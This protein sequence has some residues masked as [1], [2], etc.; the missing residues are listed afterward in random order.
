MQQQSSPSFPRHA[1][2]AALVTAG[3]ALVPAGA[4][5]LD[6][7]SIKEY[8]SPSGFRVIVKEAHGV[9]LAAIQVWI[10][11]GGY[12]ETEQTNGFAHAIEHMVFKGGQGRGPGD[13]DFKIESLGGLL[14]AATNKDWTQFA[15][16]VASQHAGQALNLMGEA[17]KN[18]Q[19][20]EQDWLIERRVLMEEI[21]R[22]R[23][24]PRASLTA[25]LYELAFEEHPYRM[26]VR[27]TP[28]QV[29][30]LQLQD[31]EAFYQLRYRPENMVVVIVGN[32]DTAAITAQAKSAFEPKPAANP[33][34]APIPQPETPCAKKVERTRPSPFRGSFL[35]LA[36]P[37]PSVADEPD[38]HVFDL[39]LTW[40]ELDGAGRLPTVLKDKATTVNVS[41]ETRRQAGLL[42]I[43]AGAGETPVTEIETL[44]LAELARLRDREPSP[45]ELA[46]VKERI[47]DSYAVDN[48]PISG[49][50]AT[51]CYYAAIDRWQFASEYVA[52]LRA[53]TPGQFHSVARKYL[54]PEHSIRLKLVARQQE[55]LQ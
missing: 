5:T 20:R 42:T 34:K 48:E 26:D 4:G 3:V 25:A 33:V 8:V 32:V 10:R 18:A 19:F 45:R 52:K 11:V 40:L 55:G 43:V 27:G 12:L 38:V 41:Y 16:T 2:L 22:F 37:A 29:Q 39:I 6:A 36:F 17:L 15:V 50:A 1:W 7:A 54:D 13:L 21:R 44:I 24:S 49:Q 53:V 9:D 51:L 30:T 28:R 23:G 46:A 35:A 31:L 14:S 47:I